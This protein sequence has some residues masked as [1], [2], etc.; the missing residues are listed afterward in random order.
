MG[1]QKRSILAIRVCWLFGFGGGGACGDDGVCAGVS[2]ALGGGLGDAVA[3]EVPAADQEGDE[4]QSG[5]EDPSA[6]FGESH[7]DEDEC[8]ESEGEV[9]GSTDEPTQ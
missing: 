3:G 6:D 7:G 8:E 2:F 9:P 1:G 4:D 5:G